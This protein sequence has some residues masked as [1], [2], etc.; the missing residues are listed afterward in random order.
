MGG[1]NKTVRFDSRV[2]SATVNRMEKEVFAKRLALQMA[3][4]C[5]RHTWLENLHGRIVPF[6]QTGDY[7]DVKVVT[8]DREIPWNQ[9]ARINDREMRRFMK[10]VVNKIY[11]VL[12]RLEDPQ[13]VG[14]FAERAQEYTYK[15]D[16][17]EFLENWFAEDF[18]P[19]KRSSKSAD[20]SGLNVL[21]DSKMD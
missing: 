6:S 20:G 19:E 9:V 15:W 12:L 14:R 16:E 3:L 10:E 4:Y 17:P 11:T 8:P 7:S 5:V 2:I 13:F 21:P 18:D 1:L